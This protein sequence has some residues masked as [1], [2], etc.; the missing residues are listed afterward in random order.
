MRKTGEH[1][2]EN[3]TQAE[4]GKHE[5]KRQMAGKDMC[6]GRAGGTHD[7]EE[8]KDDQSISKT[9]PGTAG[10]EVICFPQHPQ[11]I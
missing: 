4:T 5:G 7:W 2:G 11:R 3:R 9:I 6:A 10:G 1:R 8:Y